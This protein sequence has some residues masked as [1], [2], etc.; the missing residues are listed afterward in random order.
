MINELAKQVHENAKAHGFFDKER[1]IGEMLCLIHS[2]VSEALEADRKGWCFSKTTPVVI[3]PKEEIWKLVLGYDDYMVSNWGNVMSLD[4]VVHNG[5]GRKHTKKGRVLKPAIGSA[6]GY[7][8]V[9][10]RRNDGVRKTN[11]VAWLVA[12]AFLSQ[13]KGKIVNHLNGNK[14]IDW[15]SNLEVC[16]SAQNNQHAIDT[17]LSKR[18]KILTLW[19][20][21]DIAFSLKR[22]ERVVDIH[23]RYPQVTKS[24]IQNIK[25]KGFEK[26]TESFEMELADIMIRVM[27]LCAFKNIDLEAHIKAKMRY[28]SLREYKHGKKY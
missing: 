20:K 21:Y 18:E 8:T 4:M 1:N 17:G 9:V 24:A 16:T 27:D 26:Y 7:R 13:R 10:L 12:D 22:K 11:K 19:D 15:S 28:N 14:S 25:N 6:Q 23:K 5:I 2:E 3:K